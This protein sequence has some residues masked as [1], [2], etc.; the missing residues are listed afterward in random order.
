VH[1]HDVIDDKM[2]VA[3]VEFKMANPWL[4]VFPPENNGEHP[5]MQQVTGAKNIPQGL[6][7]VGYFML[8]FSMNLLREITRQ[9]N[10]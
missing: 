4:R 7:P 3:A 9:T 10:R 2:R 1:A 5:F 8:L 6:N